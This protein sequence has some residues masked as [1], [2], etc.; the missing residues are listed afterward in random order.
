M[1]DFIDIEELVIVEPLG[2]GVLF[3]VVW[4]N[5]WWNNGDNGLAKLGV[6]EAAEVADL[7]GGG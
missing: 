5:D 7:G 1:G 2:S 4:L 3:K 6:N